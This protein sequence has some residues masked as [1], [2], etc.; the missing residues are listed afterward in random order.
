VTR[1]RSLVAS[2]LWIA[3]A[4][5]QGP[6][7]RSGIDLV[8]VDALVTRGH[9]PITGLTAADFEIRDNGVLQTIDRVAYETVPLSVIFT[10]DASGSVAGAKLRSLRNAVNAALDSLRPGDRSALV[11]FSH[12]VQIRAHLIG[13]PAAIRDAMARVTPIGGTA[14]R[15]ATYTALALSD[16]QDTRAL[17]LVFSDGFDNASWLTVDEVRRTAQRSD[18]VM[19]GVV[20]PERIERGLS[21]ARRPRPVYTAAQT[22]FL[23]GLAS[24]TGGRILKV[25]AIDNLPKTFGAI[26][27]EFRMRYLITYYPRDVEGGGWHTIEVTVKNRHGTV[28]ARRGYQR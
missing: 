20:V 4:A 2:V 26:L 28:T 11:T 13:L 6:T 17:V 12:Q 27:R 5:G 21:S 22:D 25:D 7:F 24:S 9:A 18:A 10:V 3:A 8:R 16:T 23:E 14:L 19:Y 1:T 15:D